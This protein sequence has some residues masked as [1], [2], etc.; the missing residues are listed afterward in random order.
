MGMSMNVVGIKP[1]DEKYQRMISARD[2]CRAAGVPIPEEVRDFFG[3]DP[4]EAD[5]SGVTIY[6][7]PGA[8]YPPH[9]GVVPYQYGER[10]GFE[11]DLRSL[12][13]DI[14]ILRFYCAW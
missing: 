2:A 4:D 3:G 1:A 11:V 13:P 7:K 9:V 6:F 12:D 14:K 5:P 10:Q 8:S